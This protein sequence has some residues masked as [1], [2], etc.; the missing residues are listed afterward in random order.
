M[1]IGWNRERTGA[2]PEKGAGNR[3]REERAGRKEGAGRPEGRREP[4]RRTARAG[5]KQG[6]AG[7][8]SDNSVKLRKE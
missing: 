5:Q 1:G 6:V 8:E 2:G 7:K 3:G 4:T